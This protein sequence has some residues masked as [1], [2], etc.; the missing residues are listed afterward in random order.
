VRIAL[1]SGAADS[2]SRPRES[3]RI[4]V[5]NGDTVYQFHRLGQMTTDDQ[6]TMFVVN[7]ASLSIRVFTADGN[8]VRQFGRR[9]RGPGEFVGIDRLWFA[10]DTLVV[11]DRGAVR[12]SLFRKDGTLLTTFDL[13][14]ADRARGELL[15][16]TSSG[17]LAW[18]RPRTREF[19][20]ATFALMRDTSE[21]RMLNPV[22]RQPG[23]VLRK[24]AAGRRIAQ[25]EVYPA[26]PLLEPRSLIAYGQDG[27]Q[28]F[29]AD[30]QYS[31]DVFGANGRLIRRVVRDILKK[32]ITPRSI[33]DLRELV[34]NMLRPGSEFGMAFEQAAKNPVAPEFQQIGA[35]LAAPDGSLLVQRID[36]VDPLALERAS[37]FGSTDRGAQVSAQE[38]GRWERL[39]AQG[40]YQNSIRLPARTVP[41]YFDGQRILAVVEDDLGVQFIARFD[42]TG[43]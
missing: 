1:N 30:G 41:R 14:L 20:L 15:A 26:G 23:P 11:T 18:V 22:S 39:D 43:G 31:I 10:G 7:G 28:F 4:G 27:S 9:G 8:F 34:R 2:A 6:G 33:Q 12:A 29:A 35:L 5:V 36:H 37:G 32:P 40:R 25:A 19:D 24:H 13:R 38:E 21:L 16:R 3:L 17:W 42:V